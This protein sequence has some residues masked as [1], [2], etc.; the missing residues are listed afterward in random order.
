MKQGAV[1]ACLHRNGPMTDE[2]LIDR[3]AAMVGHPMTWHG[4]TTV[5]PRQSDSGIRTRR[6]ELV[7]RSK[8][9]A[10]GK[11]RVSSGG[12]ATVWKAIDA[13]DRAVVR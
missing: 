12:L 2:R 3:Y 4:T 5:V 9:K 10:S 8:V 6:A 13:T 11:T 1:L 7:R